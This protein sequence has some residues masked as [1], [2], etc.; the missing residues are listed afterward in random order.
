MKKMLLNL[1][2]GLTSAV[3]AAGI[4]SAVV[5]NRNNKNLDAIYYGNSKTSGFYLTNDK[6]IAVHVGQPVREE[7][8]PTFTEQHYLENKAKNN[9]NVINIENLE[10]VKNEATLINNEQDWNKILNSNSEFNGAMKYD[11]NNEFDFKL[12][13]AKLDIDFKVDF[14]KQNVIFINQLIDFYPNLLQTESIVNGVVIK[15][16]EIDKNNLILNIT[17]NLRDEKPLA[18][19]AILRYNKNFILK[20]PKSIQ[21]LSDLNIKFKYVY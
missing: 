4:I 13:R 9:N 10:N 6:N 14:S 21:N 19:K 2:I 17:N 7:G 8:L 3:V 12:F 5:I 20:V 15:S 18:S 11:K 1:G 16:Y